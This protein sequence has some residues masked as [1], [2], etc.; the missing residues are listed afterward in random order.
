MTVTIWLPMLQMT[1]PN[2]NF[3]S[4]IDDMVRPSRA[5]PSR[6]LPG[7]FLETVGLFRATSV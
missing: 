7:R 3:R 4:S 6:V 2:R 5:T 1:V